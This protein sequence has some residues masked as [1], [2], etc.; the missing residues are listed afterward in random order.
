MFLFKISSFK[1]DGKYAS[2]C[3]VSEVMRRCDHDDP[4]IKSGVRV[5]TVLGSSKRQNLKGFSLMF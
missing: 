1:V 4:E 3:L 2:F 5:A